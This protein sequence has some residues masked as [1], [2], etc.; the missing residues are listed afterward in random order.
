M[1][2][3]IR[4]GKLRGVHLALVVENKDGDG[5]PGYRVKVKYPWLS[6]QDKSYWARIVVPMAGPDRGTYFLPEPNDQVLVVFEH[7]DVNRPL[8]IGALWSKKQEPVEVNDSGK[9]NTKLIKS[10]A[11]HRIIFDDKEGAEK[12]TIVDRTKK[13]KIVLDSGN[14]IVKIEC[15]GDIVIK[16]AANVIVHSNALKLGT[17]EKLTGKGRQVLCH[18]TSTF[19]LKAS[20]SVVVDGNSVTI[21]V[22]NS[23]AAQ[24][25]GTG[26]GFLGGANVVKTMDW[27]KS[28]LSTATA[29]AAAR[30]KDEKPYREA[31]PEKHK[32]PDC[33]TAVAKL[34]MRDG[35]NGR[36][37]AAR[38]EYTL[39]YAHKGIS[40]RKA[41]GTWTY[42]GKAT[43]SAEATV[44]LPEW[45]NLPNDPAVR[46]AW[47]DAV[48]A[49]RA[50]EE[51]H[52]A[53]A[54]DGTKTL[55]GAAVRGSGSTAKAA[56][57]AAVAAF[58]KRVE[59][60]SA[61][62]ELRQ[63]EYDKKTEN[64]IKQN[65]VGGK[66]TMLICPYVKNP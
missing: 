45:E 49:L 62:I 33:N 57:A 14:K 23:P 22:N 38:T 47:A 52:V 10:R 3:V 17:L 29:I 25:S 36:P 19:G 54:Q 63:Q 48:D 26:S 60:L 28:A 6:E 61:E 20:G 37:T 21:N 50:H 5:N 16:S 59:A 27:L 9:N 32:W 56:E 64:G 7:G 18:A 66:S 12:I 53:I 1:P 55:N 35:R 24:V 41:D 2:L 51:G 39:K 40:V 30:A 4:T 58:E 46:K 13:N 34:A 8:V 15:D 31:A 11:G 42:T 44:T 65:E 43:V